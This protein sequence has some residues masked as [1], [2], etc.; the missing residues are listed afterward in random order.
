MAAPAESPSIAGMRKKYEELVELRE[1][2]PEREA[3]R[4]LQ[5][6]ELSQ[7]TSDEVI[8]T[9]RAELE[10]CK[11]VSRHHQQ[12]SLTV[13]TT[14]A[15]AVDV[16]E[17]LDHQNGELRQKIEALTPGAQKNAALNLEKQLILME[18]LTG[19]R[20]RGMGDGTKANICSGERQLAFEIDLEPDDGDEGDLGYAP[21]DL[22]GAKE[23]LPDYLRESITFEKAQAPALIAKLMTHALQ[24]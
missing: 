19:L 4:V 1:T 8:R 12:R 7:Q 20:V 9:L 17:A 6:L 16:A 10:Q 11:Q 21:I 18:D 5:T 2:E 24:E 3:K 15:D 14:I 22:S 23:G 13:S